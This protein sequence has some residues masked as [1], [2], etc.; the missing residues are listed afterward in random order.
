VDHTFLYTST[1]LTDDQLHEIE[2]LIYTADSHDQLA[3]RLYQEVLRLKHELAD[4]RYHYAGSRINRA[5]IVSRDA[6]IDKLRAE[7]AT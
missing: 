4:P 5:A 1:P 2:R 6:E 7:K 3:G